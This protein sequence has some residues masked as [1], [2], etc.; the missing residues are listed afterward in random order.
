MTRYPDYRPAGPERDRE[1]L[2]EVAHAAIGP[3][4]SGC[5]PSTWALCGDGRLLEDVLRDYLELEAEHRRVVEMLDAAN[6]DR[7][8][9]V[10]EVERLRDQVDRIE[11]LAARLE[12]QPK[13]WPPIPRE[14][15]AAVIRATLAAPDDRTLEAALESAC[16]VLTGREYAEVARDLA[17]QP[18]RETFDGGDTS[19]SIVVD[20]PEAV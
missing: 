11:A 14:H 8:C 4:P 16:V 3:S 18:A 6:Q 10:L 20:D 5:V 17:V 13:A 2:L 7:Q 12:Q 1:Y 19:D 9:L 15:L